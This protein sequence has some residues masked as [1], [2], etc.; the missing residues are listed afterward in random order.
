MKYVI[1]ID[2]DDVIADFAGGYE[3]HRLNFPDVEFPQSVEGFFEGLEPL[4]QAIAAVETLRS[5]PAIECYILTAPSTRNPNSYREKRIWVEKHFDYSMTKK[6]IICAEKNLLTGDLLIDD[7][8]EGKGQE[9]FSGKLIQFGT[10]DFPDWSTVLNNIRVSDPMR[11][12]HLEKH[13]EERGLRA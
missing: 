12:A 5:H 10:P 6:L 7:N 1:Y 8:H 3:Q 9:G 13:A 2:M 4:P 11:F